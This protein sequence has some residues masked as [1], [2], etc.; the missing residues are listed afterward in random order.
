MPPNKKNRWKERPKDDAWMFFKTGMQ[1]WRTG[2]SLREQMEAM[3]DFHEPVKYSKQS[4]GHMIST[5]I[6]RALAAEYLLKGPSVRQF[7]KFRRTHDL[8]KLFKVLDEPTRAG[9]VE[10]GDRQ[11]IEALDILTK[12]RN[13]FVEWR[14]WTEGVEWKGFDRRVDLMLAALAEVCEP[15]CSKPDHNFA[16]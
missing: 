15:G 6:L 3:P 16:T 7:G 2:H 9:I 13:A 8:L 14:Y 10:Q 12:H 5:I 11:G 1:L 4:F